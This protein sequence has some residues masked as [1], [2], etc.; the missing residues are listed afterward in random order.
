MHGSILRTSLEQRDSHHVM[1]QDLCPT[2]VTTINMKD[3]LI[4]DYPFIEEFV[5]QGLVN[6]FMNY[7][8]NK[9]SF[10]NPQYKKV[11][12]TNVGGTMHNLSMIDLIHNKDGA[13]L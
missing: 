12:Q 3:T 11:V 13:K 9:L 5:R 8:H 1:E 6:H 2:N 10:E 4:F 7:V